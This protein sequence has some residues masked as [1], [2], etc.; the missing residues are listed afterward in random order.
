MSGEKH[1]FQASGIWNGDSDGSGNINADGMEALHYGTPVAFG[2]VEGR[3]NPEAMLL[4]SLIACYSITLAL[5]LERKRLPKGK[6]T[7]Q[8][9]MEVERQPDRSLKITTIRLTPVMALPG[10]D[11]AQKTIALDMAHRAENYC[12]VSRAIK[13]NVIIEIEPTVESV[14]GQSE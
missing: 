6:I 1:L 13:G 3:S 11:E 2:G 14:T 12:I 8:G 10:L 9:I 7:V 5:L 4:S